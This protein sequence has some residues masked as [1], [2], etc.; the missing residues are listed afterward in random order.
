MK[1][2]PVFLILISSLNGFSQPCT[3][4]TNSVTFN[5]SSDYI[6]M[7]SNNA[8]NMSTEV[9]VEAWIFPT[10]WA[11]IPAQGSIICKHG[12]SNG[13]G[14][15]V[16]RA[17]GTGQLSFTIGGLNLN[18]SPASWQDVLSAPNALTLN[19]WTHVAGT[20]DGDSVNLYING[21]LVNTLLFSGTL[22]SSTNYDLKIGKLSD[23]QPGQLR[24]WTGNIDEARV[25]NRALTS[26]EISA[27]MGTQI[28]PL[29]QIGLAGYWRLNDGSG[30]TIADLSSNAISGTLAGTGWSTNVPFTTGAPQATITP[31]GNTTFCQG[32]QVI[33]SAPSGVGLLYLWSNGNTSQTTTIT[34]SGTYTVTVSDGGN[35]TA[36]SQPLTV[37]VNPSPPIPLITFNGTQLQCNASAGLQWYLNGSTLF[38]QVSQNY[39]PLVNGSYTVIVTNNNGCTSISSPYVLTTLSVEAYGGTQQMEV[40]CRPFS[41]EGIIFLQVQKQTKARLSITDLQGRPVLNKKVENLTPGNNRIKFSTENFAKGSYI[42]VISYDE[43]VLSRKFSI[44]R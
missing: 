37:T 13:E 5:G 15:Y 25:W 7:P 30:T 8:L 10:Q 32:N 11:S 26:A 17:G 40:Y 36:V 27:N 12:W 24:Y 42:L 39:T 3:P 29:L 31:S 1:K 34:T 28:D 2:I 4:N 44:I 20:F 21:V 9:T 43:Y 18:G 19:T 38:N 14:G 22:A 16:I 6:Y 41:N 33:L 35:C 23:N